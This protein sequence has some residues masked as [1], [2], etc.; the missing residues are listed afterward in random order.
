MTLEQQVKKIIS[1]TEI[2]DT[3]CY[4]ISYTMMKRPS[5][6]EEFLE[7]YHR[8]K[9]DAEVVEQEK[10]DAL[11]SETNTPEEMANLFRKQMLTASFYGLLEKARPMCEVLFPLLWEKYTRSRSDL[12][13]EHSIEF[14]FLCNDAQ[15]QGMV[16]GFDQIQD[17]YA[18]A[19]L[20]VVLGF[21]GQE[22]HIP[23]LVKAFD[24]FQGEANEADYEQGVLIA[25]NE[26]YYRF[27]FKDSDLK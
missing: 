19:Q 24:F 7:Y 21:R 5:Y 20:C 12:F 6:R 25:L 27:Y 2:S 10:Y 13:I 17:P 16:D 14:F 4:D 11:V 9:T 26:M 8:N 1:T 23:M 15:I 3:T 18:K 22:S